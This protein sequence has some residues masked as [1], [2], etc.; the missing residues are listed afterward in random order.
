MASIFSRIV[1]GEIPAY[2]VAE[3]QNHLA[4]LDIN[5]LAKGH[6]L[7]VPKR[8]EDYFFDLSDQELAAIMQF[9]KRVSASIKAVVPC[10]RVGVSV[11]GLE[12]PHAHVHLIP[13]NKSSDIN[14]SNPKLTMSKNEFL[15]LAQAIK[16]SF[17]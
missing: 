11:V 6:T 12:V 9:A 3:D 5:P 10:L 1:S 16:N 7:V 17:K 8:E 2:V 13:L 4:F 15:E 14:F